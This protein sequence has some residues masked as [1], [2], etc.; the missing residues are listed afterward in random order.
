MDLLVGPRREIGVVRLG[1]NGEV[2]DPHAYQ[3]RLSEA[4]PA[5]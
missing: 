4:G 1:G 3:N 5:G 2:P